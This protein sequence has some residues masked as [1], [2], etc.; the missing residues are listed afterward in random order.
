MT[1]KKKDFEIKN[2][3]LY[4]FCGAKLLRV[5]PDAVIVNFPVYCNKCKKEFVINIINGK[6]IG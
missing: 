1:D 5:T 2:D 4:H 6:L 3:F